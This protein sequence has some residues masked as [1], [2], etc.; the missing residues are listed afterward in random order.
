MT[1]HPL[2]KRLT[3][4][5]LEWPQAALLASA[6]L[7]ATPAL[8][9]AQS[10]PEETPTQTESS[11]GSIV[12]KILRIG[13]ET[14]N[15]L[16][17]IWINLA[18]C[19]ANAEVEFRLDQV[20]SETEELFVFAGES[21]NQGESRDGEGTDCRRVIE[22]KIE[23]TGIDDQRVRLKTADI[24][25]AAFNATDE[26]CA[27]KSATPRIWFLKLSSA[28]DTADAEEDS[29]GYLKLNIDTDPP[30]APTSIKG[31]R[32]EDAIRVEWRVSG[33]NVESFE[34]YVDSSSGGTPIRDA[35]A[36][37]PPSDDGG[38][39][40]SD[41]GGATNDMC[42]SGRLREGGSWEDVDYL[43]RKSEGSSTATGTT[44]SPDEVGGESAAVAVVALDEAE[45]RSP[46]SAV[47]CVYV[48]PTTGFKDAL[49]EDVPQGCP[50]TA[51]GPAQLE[52]MLPIALAL[53]VIAYRRRRRT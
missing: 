32:G 25:R 41:T 21:C 35:G 53:G 44:L 13:G 16:G 50:C 42:G 28:A 22:N 29:W 40:E 37:P 52:G 1:R 43:V 18:D 36:E 38:A 49:G 47:E 19:K 12:A 24:I 4:A 9:L 45:N 6:T 2:S 14:Q 3:R 31:G 51:A 8:S 26:S 15:D 5:L 30:S 33:Q 17:T 23:I 34:I 20:P 48:V 46:L 39:G 27:D 11:G 7:L 10:D